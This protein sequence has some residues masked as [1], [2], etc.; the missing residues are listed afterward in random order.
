MKRKCVV[1]LIALTKTYKEKFNTIWLPKE[2]GNVEW[3]ILK[4][5]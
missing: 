1:R 2:G 4:M 5:K 3:K